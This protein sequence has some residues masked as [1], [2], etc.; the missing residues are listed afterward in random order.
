M[1]GCKE[2]FLGA[3]MLFFIAYFQCPQEYCLNLRAKKGG[4]SPPVSMKQL[5][6]F[7]AC[8]PV[9]RHSPLVRP[10]CLVSPS[11]A[12]YETASK[13]TARAYRETRPNR[14]FRFP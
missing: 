14:L 5:C 4:Q 11:L 3:W 12:S 10:F 8:K 2:A 1:G 6:S 9:C 13:M 7:T